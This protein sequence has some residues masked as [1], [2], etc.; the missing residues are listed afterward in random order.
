MKD[1]FIKEILDLQQESEEVKLKY[2]DQNRIYKRLQNRI[3]VMVSFYDSTETDRTLSQLMKI[4]YV[5]SQ[6]LR[7]KKSN[8]SFEEQ[9]K[10]NGWDTKKW[11]QLDNIEKQ[12]AELKRQMDEPS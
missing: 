2:G 7:A 8:I 10:L 5:S 3:K 4:N 1:R 12:V 6:M 11:L 9:A